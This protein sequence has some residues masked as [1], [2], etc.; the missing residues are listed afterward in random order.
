MGKAGD[1]AVVVMQDD[2][3]PSQ[4]DL[5]TAGFGDDAQHSHCLERCRGDSTAEIADHGGLAGQE[6][7]YIDGVDAGIDATDDHR[8]HRRHDLQVCGEATAGEGLVALS[9]GL[10]YSHWDVC[11]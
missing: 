10:N 3:V 5:T 4:S 8:L 11:F 7:E 2:E 9:Q 6:A 1:A